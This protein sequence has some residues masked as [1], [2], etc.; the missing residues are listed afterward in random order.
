M[1]KTQILINLHIAKVNKKNASRSHPPCIH[2][3]N[4]RLCPST[5]KYER[6][7]IEMRAQKSHAHACYTYAYSIYQASYVDAPTKKYQLM[8]WPGNEWL[9]RKN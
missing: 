6:T 8:L 2:V 5:K 1:T 7:C 3:K 4:I 9:M